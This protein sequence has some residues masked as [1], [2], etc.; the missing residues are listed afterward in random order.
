MRLPCSEATSNRIAAGPRRRRRSS[1]GRARRSRRNSAGAAAPSSAAVPG[2][3]S[4]PRCGKATI[5]TSST[6][7]SASRASSTASSRASPCSGWT[8]TCVRSAVV[9]KLATRRPSSSARAAIGTSAS[10]SRS[11]SASAAIRPGKPAAG[12][13]GRQRVPRKLLSRWMWPSMNAG[14]SNAPSSS[15]RRAPSGARSATRPSVTATSA[16]APSGSVA[17][18]RMSALIGRCAAARQRSRCGR[19]SSPPRCGRSSA[20]WRPRSRAVQSPRG[21]PRVRRA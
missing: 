6:S 5:C 10:T 18:P 9:P 4:T 1:P 20:R 12:T 7:R 13:C 19:C 14:T 8:S 17:P 16:R 3:A 11:A 21:S 2:A 15:I